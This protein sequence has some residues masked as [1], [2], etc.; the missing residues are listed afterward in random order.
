MSQHLAAEKNSGA[1]GLGIGL[2]YGGFGARIG[3]NPFDQTTL[4]L[5]LGYNLSGLGING[6]IQYL[7]PS[8]KQSQFYFSVLYGTNSSIKIKGLDESTKS[9]YGPSFGLGIRI[10]SLRHEGSF[11]D[12]GL[13][14]PIRSSEYKDDLDALENNPSISGL[15]KPWPVLITAGYN[16]SLT[17]RK[18][19]ES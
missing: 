10:N 15:T 6:G 14:L 8:N 18:K 12:L 3:Y 1:A 17:K 11:W 19:S 7:L 5:G 4:F 13:V 16:F 9:Y 2:P